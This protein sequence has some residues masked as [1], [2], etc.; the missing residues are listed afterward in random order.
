MN[1]RVLLIDADPAFTATLHEQ[2]GRYR[3]DVTAE[4]DPDK[5]I[6]MASADPPAL[7]IISVEEPEKAGFRV[8]QKS[9]K[10]PLAKVPVMLVT[11]S[12]SADSFSKHRG[13]KVHADDYLDKRGAAVEVVVGKIDG[14]IELGDPL[15]DDELSIPIEDDI[16]LDLGGAMIVDETVG[17]EHGEFASEGD[18]V[19]PADGIKVDSVV[20]AETDAAFAA[21]LGDELVGALGGGA[22]AIPEPVGAIPDPVPEPVHDSMM[23]A[24][25]EPDEPVPEPVH[26]GGAPEPEDDAV[27]EFES[28]SAIATRVPG[29]SGGIRL[30]SQPAIPID[31]D[32]IMSLDDDLP[33]EVDE[34]PAAAAPA[35]IHSRPPTTPPA[36]P[37]RAQSE[38][39]ITSAQPV[40]P[41]SA[42]AEIAATELAAAE[43]APR[44]GS[45]G[46]GSHPAIDLGLEA[47]AQDAESEQSG[48][49]DRRALRKIGELERQIAQLKA[50][51]D[52]ARS[53]A[54]SGAKGPGREREFLNL[55][56]SILSKD[57]ELRVA[58][59]ALADRDG[60]IAELRDQVSQLQGAKAGA[61][62][63][64]GELEQRL[65]ES[66]SRHSQL[67][68]AQR[69]AAAQLAALQ[70]QFEERSRAANDAETARAQLE[71][72][73]AGERANRATSASE[74][75][76]ALRV[77]REQLIARHAADLAAIRGDQQAA[78]EAALAAL[79]DELAVAQADALIEAAASAKKAAKAEHDI[80]LSKTERELTT[81]NVKLRN[82]LGSEVE[83]LKGALA[84]AHAE[85]EEAVTA[86]GASHMAA[87]DELE[88]KYQAELA[89][90]ERIHTDVRTAADQAHAAAIAD[91]HGDLDRA[92]AAND[93]KLTS[94]KRDYE[95]RAAELIE[96]HRAEIAAATNAH[97]QALTTATTSHRQE[98]AT[99]TETHRQQLTTATEAHRQDLAA[100]HAERD[101]IADE[102]ERASAGHIGTLADAEARREAEVA[103]TREAADREASELRGQLA[104]TKRAADEAA[105]RHQREHDA[106]LAAHAQALED[107]A[108]AHEAELAAKDAEHG[109]VK[110]ALE[111]EHARAI[112][113]KDADHAR[114][115]GAKDAEHAQA[116]KTLA[117]EH[118]RAVSDI[119][120]ERDELRRGLSTTR[121]GLKRAEGELSSAVQTIADR[122]ADLRTHA[123]A[124]AERDQ[125]IA[126]LRKEIEGLEQENAS[127]QEQVLRAYQ[128]I[129][130]DEAMVARARKAMAIAL[131]VLDD[132]GNPTS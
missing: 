19:G 11:S 4:S 22:D 49:Y 130:T 129:K 95:Q 81:Q 61:D 29:A 91:L 92:A 25:D 37:I 1:R 117:A 122:N 36:P 132:Q 114:I 15:V 48:V 69:A 33:V 62:S 119:T 131:T 52:R 41:V 30:E 17:E 112:A 85:H 34:E 72:D 38:P 31:D 64:H 55:R 86:A 26:D 78:R 18:T 89:E 83:R 45:H 63:K 74:A 105:A 115:V 71:R 109:G 73:L 35:E 104:A 12:M 108:A 96:S 24:S 51:L 53:A 94:A 59:E 116:T 13:L 75:E 57:K 111:A 7:I 80:A 21:L 99:L 87:L 5:A 50:E 82:D 14:L 110:S 60:A 121:D 106:A 65:S 103:A 84:Q 102:A 101:Q 3:V 42:P 9:R 67:E 28:R 124:I 27:E 8:F 2:L 56:E 107:A 127:Y 43:P 6:A 128:K 93:V 68:V 44:P 40:P 126:D 77:E 47:V 88:A 90:K 39:V 46:S 76:R 118:G 20:E 54:E 10:G 100:A 79:R 123:A 23:A 98:V 16:S 113:A 97:E 32:E 70:Q 120:S 66:T 58:K 125:R